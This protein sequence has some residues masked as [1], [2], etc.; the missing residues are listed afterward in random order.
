MVVYSGNICSRCRI[1]LD[2]PINLT[3]KPFW[4][5]GLVELSYVHSLNTIQKG[6]SIE[7]LENYET[8]LS[9]IS[10]PKTLLNNITNVKDTSILQQT[11]LEIEIKESKVHIHFQKPKSTLYLS[12]TI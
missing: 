4:E 2:N 1:R 11:N 10:L 12:K 3:E 5:V 9:A 7:V 6:E 8:L